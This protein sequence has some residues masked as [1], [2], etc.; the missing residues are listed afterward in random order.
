MA[1]GD[2]RICVYCTEPY[3]LTRTKPG[4]A[5][6][7]GDCGQLSEDEK[8]NTRPGGIMEY[9]HKTAPTIKILTNLN[10]AKT[11]IKSTDR[12]GGQGVIRGMAERKS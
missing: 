4:Y 9:A 11:I 8:G 2:K 5:N 6:E 3:T 12:T 1:W 7:C 10:D